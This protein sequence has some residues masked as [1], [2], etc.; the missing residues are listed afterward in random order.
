M[1]ISRRQFVV[2]STFTAGFALAVQPIVN[3][4]IQ[5]S[6]KNLDCPPLDFL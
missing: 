6:S 4:A 5:T 3:S 2:G 1:P